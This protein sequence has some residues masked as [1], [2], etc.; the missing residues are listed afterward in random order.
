MDKARK[1]CIGHLYLVKDGKSTYLCDTIE[2]VSRGL[3]QLLSEEENRAKKVPKQTAIPV[4]RYRVALGVQ[5]PKFSQASYA[6][7]FYHDYNG[8]YVPRLL[9]VPAF[10]GILIHA[11]T[12]ENSSAGCIIVGENKVVGAVVN[13]RKTWLRLMEKHFTPCRKRGEACYITIRESFRR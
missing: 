3:S 6:G 4:G 11:G 12:N 1:Y 2:D 9:N 8:G 10:E 5:S 7:G 13:S